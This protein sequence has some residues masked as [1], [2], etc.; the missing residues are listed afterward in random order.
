MAMKTSILNLP[1]GLQS[2][3][4]MNNPFYGLKA[5][6]GYELGELMMISAS[7]ERTLPK[8]NFQMEILKARMAEGYVKIAFYDMETGLKNVD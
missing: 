2:E 8:S 5:K 4:S 3:V 6:G 7:T 1:Y